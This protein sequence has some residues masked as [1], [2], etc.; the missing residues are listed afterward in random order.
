MAD[1]SG[2][3]HIS[4]S[5]VHCT[6]TARPGTARASSTAST[7]TSSAPFCPK[8]PAP[9]T[10]RTVTCPAASPSPAA[11]ASRSKKMP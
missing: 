11:I 1:P 7:A 4:S 3:Q 6:R 10:Y 5:R 2:V 8:T 9:S